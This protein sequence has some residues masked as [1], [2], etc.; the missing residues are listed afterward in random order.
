MKRHPYIISLALVLV[1]SVIIPIDDLLAQPT[2]SVRLESTIRGV[3]FS[4][5]VAGNL[6]GAQQD[7]L[8]IFGELRDGTAVTSI[9]DFTSRVFDPL[10]NPPVVISRF[11]E[12][13]NIPLLD[14][15]YGDVKLDDMDGN[16]EEDIIIAARV[17]TGNNT[18]G[19]LSGIYLNFSSVN[20][21]PTFEWISEIGLPFV[22]FSQVE[23]ADFDGDGIPDIA[24]GGMEPDG[25][26]VFGVY[27]N[28]LSTAGTF[29]R[30]N[31]SPFPTI[32]PSMLTAGDFDGDGDPDLLVGGRIGDEQ[33][34][35][36]LFENTQDGFVERPTSLPNLI[37]PGGEFADVDSDGDDD[38][39]LTGGEFGPNMI[40]GRSTLFISENGSFT[41]HSTEFPG[42]FYGE[43]EFADFEGDGDLDLFIEGLTDPTALD[44]AR[45]FIFENR[46]GTLEQVAD[47]PSLIFG[48]A[49]WVDY[50]NNGRLDIVVTGESNDEHRVIIYEYAPRPNPPP[51]RD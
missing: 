20:E 36:R 29:A 11:S 39:I 35:V 42:V 10:P 6:L 4:D 12:Q 5:V 46:G 26:V 17:Q 22:G 30:I 32:H 37:F 40:E 21:A 27:L 45:L 9:Y 3:K 31:P 15:S 33:H 2:S 1:I 23:T 13:L 34:V 16:G 38:L 24:M 8:F 48:G 44:G 25:T 28:R 7:D 18:Y 43:A 47:E 14:F 51:P 49:E 41:P 19:A 50:D